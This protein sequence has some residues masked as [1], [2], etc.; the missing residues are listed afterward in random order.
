MKSLYVFIGGL[1][2]GSGI[3]AMYALP[4]VWS[5]GWAMSGVTMMLMALWGDRKQR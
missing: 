3:V 4:S 2:F 1:I 5:W